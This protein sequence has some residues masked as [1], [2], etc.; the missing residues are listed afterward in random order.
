MHGCTGTQFFLEL[1]LERLKQRLE[2]KL[3]QIQ[4]PAYKYKTFSA[5]LVLYSSSALCRVYF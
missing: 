1:P 5:A 3:S 4:C 2:M